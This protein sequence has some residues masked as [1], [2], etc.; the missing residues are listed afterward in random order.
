M[1]VYEPLPRPRVFGLILYV[2]GNI[3][4]DYVAQFLPTPD[5]GAVKLH[6]LGSTTNL[7]L[8]FFGAVQPRYVFLGQVLLAVSFWGDRPMQCKNFW[9]ITTYRL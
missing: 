7:K 5:Q 9:D 8:A 1:P 3:C 6:R 2:D 4:D